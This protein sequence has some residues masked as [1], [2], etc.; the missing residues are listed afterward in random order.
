MIRILGF[1]CHGPGSVPG[2]G[3]EIPQPVRS[4]VQGGKKQTE[5]IKKKS[6]KTFKSQIIHFVALVGGLNESMLVDYL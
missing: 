5:K 1:R 2:W 4:F 6:F 3:S